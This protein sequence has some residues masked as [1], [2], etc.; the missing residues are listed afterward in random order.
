MDGNLEAL[1]ADNG[2]V[3]LLTLP[4]R[5]DEVPGSD[6][7]TV[8]AAAPVSGPEDAT[9]LHP[10]TAADHDAAEDLISERRHPL[11]FVWQ[12]DATQRF[13]VGSDEFI[14]LVGP[15]TTAAFG[16]QWSE[17]AAELKL[18][19]D[20]QVAR[21][22][23]SHE[24]WSGIIIGWPIDE[25]SERLPVELS[26]LPVFD[27]DRSF[28][29][30]RGFGV[31]RDVSRINQLMRTRRERPIGFMPLPDSGPQSDTMPAPQDAPVAGAMPA[32]A[33]A[34]PTAPDPPRRDPMAQA[35]A[36]TGANVLPFRFGA[37]PEPKA[38]TLSPVERKA[39]SDLAQEL[40][41]RLRGAPDAPVMADSS[42]EGAL[43]KEPEPASEAAAATSRQDAVG[44]ALP[45]ATDA[46]PQQPVL[47]EP[48][49]LDRIPIGVLI[50]GRDALLHANRHFLELTGYDSLDALTA[51]GGLAA[52]FAEPGADALAASGAPQ[53]LSIRTRS[54]GML[55]ADG[56]LFSVPWNGA[57]A[58]A[59][60]LANGPEAERRRA[61]ELALATAAEA[62]DKTRQAKEDAE[63]DV[64]SVQHE[65]SDARS[66]A[67]VAES[68]LREAKEATEREMT[69]LRRDLEAAQAAA[70]HANTA[71]DQARH[72][73][74]H[75]LQGAHRE[76]DDA[77]RK[78]QDTESEL[79][80]AKR[81][82]QRATAAKGEFLARIS[83]EIRTPLNAIT[84]FAEVVMAERFGPI[85]NERYREYVK[86]IHGAGTHLV[87]MLND[88]LDLNKI[89][90]G[91]LDL[92]FANIGLNELIAQCVSVMQPQ[93]NRA[94]I[95]IR[96][97]LTQALPSVVADERSLRQIVLNLLANSIKLTGPGG[98][99]IVSTAL[100][101]SG[102]VVVRVRDTGVGMSAK[103][104]AA[105]LEPFQQSAT[106]AGSGGSG[107]G[108]SLTKA[109]AAA[110][111]ANFGIKSAPNAGTIAEIA[112]PSGRIAP[113]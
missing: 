49:F 112:F 10:A 97:S 12:M 98:Q 47:I 27:R 26:G 1:G 67:Q 20:N 44:E 83:H 105:A 106:A 91:Q 63:R 81:E 52:L 110:N 11:R 24:T 41:A 62:H 70:E 31:C 13:V 77:S 87:S 104:I 55:P 88:L 46:A 28:R 85:G 76:R 94:R 99:V 58:L 15:R 43:A 23:A 89:E 79:Q 53:P 56:R 29:G 57:S 21:A 64:Q 14:A 54:G 9:E 32:T 17:I 72:D 38:P 19:P 3:L 90:S 71:L 92:S 34:V 7:D 42:V 102:E 108:L 75:A 100:S 69:A 78:L 66:A 96:S 103:D 2:R 65:L 109:L 111:G 22:V 48:S 5:Q 113:N 73:A 107:L 61:A 80:K 86:D 50:Y 8:A 45:A 51:A 18:D 68:A 95:I 33:A 40:T 59:L 16:R 82:A 36:P 4:H 60:I 84:G 25:T 101:D 35:A 37:A 39:F 93:A 74:E 6:A 30:Y